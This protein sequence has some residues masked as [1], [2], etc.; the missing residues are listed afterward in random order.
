MDYK[1]INIEQLDVIKGKIY[2][3]HRQLEF[4]TPAMFVPFGL[5]HYNNT[6]GEKYDIKL[7]FRNEQ[8]QFLS[9]FMNKINA[10]D[11]YLKRVYPKSEYNSLL[12][13]NNLVIKIP[14]ANEKFGCGVKSD[15][16]ALPTVFSIKKGSWVRCLV[17]AEKVWHYQDRSGCLLVAK[18]FVLLNQVESDELKDLPEQ[19]ND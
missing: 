18:Q 3:N 9:K 19:T 12:K 1:E 15:H 4:W 5:D 10:I 16:E 14:F 7:A 13:S 11:A 2:H 17:S 8:G 6:Y